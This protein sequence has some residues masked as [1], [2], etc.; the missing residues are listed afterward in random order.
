[1]LYT[2]PN[3]TFIMAK[4]G[5]HAVTLA[6]ASGSIATL[7]ASI[8]SA[9]ASNPTNA[10]IISLLSNAT[11]IVSGASLTL[12]ARECLIAVGATIQA[13]NSSVIVPLVQ[14]NSGATNVSVAGGT[15]DGNGA[16]IQGI[17][18]P[19]AGRVNV[20]MVTV[21]NCG[22]DCILLKGQGTSNYDN[23]MTVTR[24]DC[25]GSPA[26][27]GVSIQNS[28]QAAVLDNFCHNNSAG[29]YVNCAWA[30]VANNSCISNATGIDV[31]GG[32]DNVVANNT[33]DDN[34]TGVHAGASNNM[35]LS[36]EAGNNSTA[37]INSNGSGNTFSDNLFG[38]GNASNFTSGGSGNNVIAYKTSLSASGQNYFYPPLIDDQHTNTIVNGMGRT[39]L[40]ISSTTI[41]SVQSQYNSARSGNPNNVIV[42]HL[43]GTFT[44]GATAL[45]LESNTCVLL[46]GMIQIN[47][48]TGASSAIVGDNSP[49]RV[50]I[51]GGVIDG[52]DLT[53]NNGISI[54]SAGTIQLDSVAL[55][56][57]GDPNTRKGGSDVVH[58]SGGSTPQII[59]RCYLTNGA[60]RGIWFQTSGIKRVVSD[61]EAT[62]VNQDGVDC[63]SSTS[64]SVVKFCYCHDLVR[65]GVFFEQSASHDLA[66][67][68]VCNDD[69]RDINVYN[70]STTP[71]GSTQ[72]NTV[73]CNS[74]KDGNALRNGSTGTNIVTSSHNFFFN[75]QVI[76][77]SISSEQYGV[78]NYYSQNYQGGGSLSTAGT[79]SFFNSTD[80]SS[81]QFMLDSNSGLPALA[82]NAATTNGTPVVLG[83]ASGLDNDQWALIPTERGYCRIT[84]KKSKLVMN[85]SG[86]SLNAGAPV[87][88]YTFGSGKNDQW[89]LMLAGNGLVYFINRLSGLCLDVPGV[90]AG[91]QLDQQPYTGAANQQFKLQSTPPGAVVQIPFFLSATPSSQT[92]IAGGSNTFTVMISTNLNFTGSVNLSVS[93]L[94]PNTT[95][96]V[97]P[98]SLNGNGSSTLS[99]FTTTNTPVGIYPVTITAVGSGITNTATVSLTVNSGVVASPGTLVWAGASG[100]NWSTPQNWTN[101]TTPGS[102]PPGTNNILIFTNTGT[103]TASALTSTGSGIVVP[104]NINSSV[105]TS[106]AVGGLFDYANAINTSPN[107]H[108]IGIAS[109]AT[110]TVAT[111]FQVGGFTAFLLGDNNTTKLTVTGAG[112]TLLVTNGGVTVSADAATGPA[113]NSLLDLSGLD[114]FSMNGT[115][116]RIG[117][118]GSGSFHHAS[119]VIYLAKANTLMLT[120]AGY[121]D[122]GVG[123]PSSGNPGLY[124]G[125]NASTFGNGSQLYLGISNNI[126]VDYATL[127]RGDKNVFVGFNPAF[128]NQNPSVVIRGTNGISD[129]VGVYVV[130]DGSAG[131]QANSAPSTNDFSGGA[132]DALINYLC[133]GRG[134]S[135]NN[136]S[137]G[138]SG[139]LTFDSGGINAN[140]LAIGFIYPSGSNSPA[141]GT[142]NVNGSATLTV[143]SNLLMAQA[144]NVA[145]QTAFPQATLNVN[146]G[147]VQA[148]N[149]VARGG[150]ATINLNSGTIDLQ[151]GQMTNVSALNIGDGVSSSAQLLNGA[152]I[153]ST[154]L[155]TIAVNGILAGNTFVTAPG[156]IVNGTIL[157]GAI[158]IGAITNS[159]AIIFSA[160]GNYVVAVQNADGAPAG[161]WDF[162]QTSGPLNMAATNT[163][164]F[165]I[166]LQ[167]FANGQIDNVTN[168]NADTNYDWTIATATGGIANF[169]AGEFAIDT[170]YFGNDLQGG[171]F[172]VRTNGNSLILSF[173]NNHPPAAGIYWMY[174][175]PG[176]TA[177]PISDLASNWSDPDDDPVILNDVNDSSTN[178][179]AVNFDSH[180]IY[181]PA[182]N[183]SADAIFYT[184]A[185]VR[186][187]PPAIY[188]RGDTQRTATGEIIL[189]PPP[190]L[191]GANVTGTI[192]AFN[193]SGGIPGG[194]YFV[195]ASTNMALPVCQWT[196]IATNNFDGAGYFSF[197]NGVNPEAPQT[198][199]SLQT[200]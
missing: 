125:H 9:R 112:A 130:G 32:N 115:Q 114:N 126:F 29:I 17:Y 35:I 173:T 12:D 15:F 119:G 26:H 46:N 69:G 23:E 102:G 33:C 121:T 60:A 194:N 40:T 136:S 38:S 94:P 123:S 100:V 64:G 31:A 51:S 174:Q 157:P 39:D 49:K 58:L 63:D 175:T 93:G 113:N 147:T 71:R 165:T 67:G 103:V 137:V 153:V 5:D 77:A 116:I 164:P 105:D 170:S 148:S 52:S 101:I 16:N 166:R 128:I 53:G 86:A 92:I 172:Y 72:Y 124:I 143:N 181:Y 37:G 120:S 111:N 127:G 57:F 140:T 186:T 21:R 107:Y 145:G 56:R 197:T 151:G 65:Y 163:N 129:R 76:N 13:A 80:V 134:R 178:G 141:I 180:F 189:L 200:H 131:A 169:I 70:N 24:C 19:A 1:M 152:K 41:D 154:N 66:L 96:N 195:L 11:Y 109:G 68:N 8:A 20:D 97:N 91:T 133:V 150:T 196:A 139:V 144:A 85:V 27:A 4:S 42:L 191:S 7:Q 161:G 81:N 10:I 146:G 199:Y 62:Q 171:Y 108:N 132:V 159:G 43:N 78:E 156:L 2:S 167:S 118:E 55:Q 106:F 183:N 110:L 28:T 162:L 3:V 117:V 14:I 89:M 44:V 25:S 135:G 88:Q 99:I 87:I 82:L 6:D 45:T 30:T 155:I 158:G 177:V 184:I 193:G 47:G 185:D 34:G 90:A 61:T 188:R 187:N 22:Q 176:G 104:A 182:N 73:L 74:L 160:G 142:V 84:N 198:F 149:I 190:I 179:V 168:F 18:A 95:S 98:A 138:G 79:E 122:S 48:A 192:L 75:N 83:P 36:N 50:C 54:G 59:T